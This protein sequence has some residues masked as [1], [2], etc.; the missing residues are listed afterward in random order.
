MTFKKKEES[1]TDTLGNR[2]SRGGQCGCLKEWWQPCI[3][4]ARDFKWEGRLP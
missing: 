2:E 3:V 1:G 4:D